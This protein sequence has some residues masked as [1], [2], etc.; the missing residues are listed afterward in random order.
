[1]AQA[2]AA[3]LQKS[4]LWLFLIA[5]ALCLGLIFSFA[6]SYPQAYIGHDDIPGDAL[7][8]FKRQIFFAVI[9][10]FIGLWASLRAPA[11]FQKYAL[12]GLIACFG[13]MLLAIIQGHIQGSTR[14]AY[15]WLRLGPLPPVQPSEFAKLFYVIYLAQLFHKGSLSGA[16]GKRIRRPFLLALSA[17]AVL[18]IGQHDLGMLLLIVLVTL[19]MCF[20]A[21]APKWKTAL[22][23]ALLVG[24]GVAFGYLNEGEYGERW[25]AFL[26]PEA[27]PSGAGYHVLTMLVTIAQGGIWGQGLGFNFEKQC[28]LPE[29][30]TDA[31]FCVIACQLGFVRTLIFLLFLA[32]IVYLAFYIG[33]GQPAFS[34]LLS[35]GIGALLG[36]QMLINIAVALKLMPITGLTL[37]FF[38]YGGSSLVS[39]LLAAGLVSSV[40]RH[41]TNPLR[42]EGA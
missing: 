20:L 36:L 38:S 29:A 23:L 10:C 14:G 17:F 41:R 31:I 27:D 3:P 42:Q 30:H 32:G 15:C 5:C 16:Y 24:G 28:H 9:G 33:N 26:H 6:S 37:P 4:N 13:A 8:F 1:M 21:G 34:Y 12:G 25:R 22:Y 7:K 11:S 39:S 40:Y 18:L 19:A 35:C 2:W